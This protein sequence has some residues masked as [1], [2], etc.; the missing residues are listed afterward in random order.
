MTNS[1]VWLHEESLRA[2]HKVFEVAPKGSK[3]VFVWDDNYFR[4]ANYSLKRLV[5]IYETLCELPV[6]IIRGETVC[7]LSEL[8]PSSIYVPA[9]SNPRI[10]TLIER[11]KSATTVNVVNDD[12]F[13]Q[14]D[15]SLDFKRF[16]KY[17][18]LAEKTA[19]LKNGGFSD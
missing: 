18:N 16:F 2:N 19:F 15:E 12:P 7:S 10:T 3:A 13:V 5:F 6:D 11:L 8:M 14:I 1:L 4:E 9:S 17:W